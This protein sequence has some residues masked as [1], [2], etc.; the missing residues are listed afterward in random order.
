MKPLAGVRVLDLTKVLA[1]PLCTQYLGDFGAEVI[2]VEPTQIGDDTR[3]WPPFRGET[4]AIF[5]SVNRNKR[6]VAVDLKSE[7]GRAIVHKLA[8]QAD[9]VLESYGTGVAERL[10]IDYP[11]LKGIKP[12]L[13]YL[14][15]SGFGRTGPLSG[16]LGY[17]VILQAFSG[18]MA[19]TGEPGGNPIR[20]PFSPV[21]QTTGLHAVTAIM[22]A[23]MERARTGQGTRIEVS[24]FETAMSFL[25]YNFHVYWENGVEPEKPGSGHESLVPYQ[26]FDTADKPV[27]IGVA[28]DNLWRRFCGAVGR[29][30]LAQDPRF[31]TSADRSRN[32]APC[33]GIVQDILRTRGRDD[34][35]ALMN[36]IGVPC[37]PINSLREALD[38]PQT[39]A[40]GM[41][42]QYDHPALGS[43][44]TIAQ[45]I[46]FNNEPRNVGSPPPMLGQHT[47]EVL[48]E[49][50]YADPDI[51]RLA[52][53]GVILDGGAV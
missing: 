45:P 25:S 31:L 29:E 50:T 19:L 8:A 14:S 5:L 33:V 32:R 6:S 39:A 17:D 27:L 23:L 9:V 41:V 42:M 22:A 35:L 26:A 11:T 7:A 53:A 4:G 21:D 24:L 49:L 44:K 52:T 34:W 16:S 1:G 20:S 13:I 51:D 12:D 47:R 28:N 40:R 15:I 36:K 48:R 18:I 2:K 43:I 3:R 38:H 10:G 37:A 30:E 46:L